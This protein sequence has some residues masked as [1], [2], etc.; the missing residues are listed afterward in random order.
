MSLLVLRCQVHMDGY[1]Y[2]QQALREFLAPGDG[3]CVATHE[4]PDGE[5][6]GVMSLLLMS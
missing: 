4:S 6:L 2:T 5:L 3:K 1:L